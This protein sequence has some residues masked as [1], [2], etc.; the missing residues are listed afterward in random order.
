MNG[1]KS[2]VLYFD[3]MRLMLMLPVEQRGWLI[4]A[5]TDFAK[6]AAE[7]PDADWETIAEAYPAMTDDC[8]LVLEYMC[9]FIARDTDTWHSQREAR[10]R[11]RE[12]KLRRQAEGEA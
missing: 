10:M 11:R 9:S 7:D 2:F 12:E 4:T 1:K 3:A 6:I 8:L 5:M